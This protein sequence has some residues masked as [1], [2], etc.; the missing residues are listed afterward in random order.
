MMCEQLNKEPKEEDIP[1][2]WEDFP[3]FIITTV[4][5][6]NMLGDRV[7]PEIGFVGKDY[8]N[9]KLFMEQYDIYDKEFFFELLSWLDQR[10]IKKSAEQL[11]RE[12]DK[13]K[14]QSSG[15]K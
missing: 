14:R 6:Y 13:L 3:D 2:D 10:A 15:K 5:I 9:L 1:L 7:Y 12:Y 4:N 11:K 8:T